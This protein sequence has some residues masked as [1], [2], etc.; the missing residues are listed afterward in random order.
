MPAIRPIRADDRAAWTGLWRDYLDFYGTELPD[1]VYE[2]QWAR[3]MAAD[4]V[5]GLFAEADGH[6]AGLA[7]FI[8]HDHGWKIRPVCYLQDL[9]VAEAA[10]GSGLGRQL[11]E[12]VYGAADA[13]G[14]PDVYWLTQTGNV[15]ARRLYD[16]IGTLTDFVKYAR[17]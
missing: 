13:A 14:A 10:R 12:A 17:R 1:A 3:L 15:S 16:R 5:R 4:R 2:A 8:F 6:P 9:Y 11:V 7:H